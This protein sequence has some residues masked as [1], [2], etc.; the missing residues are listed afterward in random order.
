MSSRRSPRSTLP[1]FVTLVALGCLW[2]LVSC[3]R[4]FSREPPLARAA[5]T[6]DLAKVERLLAAGAEVDHVVSGGYTALAIA[7]RHGHAEI[8]RVLLAHGADPNAARRNQFAPLGLAVTHG[9]VEI[10][11]MLL[12]HGAQ[13]DAGDQGGTPLMAA[14][15]HNHG[16]VK[17][18][19]ADTLGY[20]GRDVDLTEE[21]FGL[22]PHH[23]YKLTRLLLEY[24][25]DPNAQSSNGY[26]PLGLAV[27]RDKAQTV[28]LLL[29]YGADPRIADKEGMTPAEAT[30]NERIAAILRAHI[31]EQAAGTQAT[32]C[33][34][35]RRGDLEEVERLLSAGAEVNHVLG[36]GYTALAAA[37]RGGH[38]TVVR[39]LLA[40]GADPNGHGGT[41]PL[42]W[43]IWSGQSSSVRLLLEAGA[44]PNASGKYGLTLM[45]WAA[46]DGYVGIAEMLLAHGA[47]VDPRILHA[48][49][50]APE[51]PPGPLPH[52]NY[53]MVRLLL[54]HGADLNAQDSYG[55]TPLHR[56]VAGGGARMVELLLSYGADPGIP[57]ETGRTPLHSAV[58]TRQEECARLLVEAG[59][60]INAIFAGDTPLDLA[61]HYHRERMAEFL[62]EHGAKTRTELQAAQEED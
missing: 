22:V 61:L 47:R 3:E 48:A 58:L 62:R 51:G 31:P 29:S 36:G 46:R 7:V 1:A 55:T 19:I 53:K 25:A 49:V 40:H 35:A 10:A 27:F 54:D 57:E 42:R 8:V 43:A 30:Q 15:F 9:R 23:Q 6:G 56:A 11:R 37:A 16:D 4:I 34:A 33:R 60:N 59:A 5:R 50:H 17:G 32:L 28:E 24:G 20:T 14:A 21:E 2:P 12:E 26:T 41:P 44:D 52:E 45:H 39:L 13:V 18:H 38:A